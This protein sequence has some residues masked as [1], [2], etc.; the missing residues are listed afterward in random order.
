ME[1]NKLS[2]GR[3]AKI[4][5]KWAKTMT[6]WLIK[7]SSKN[8]KQWQVISFEGSKGGESRGI[9]DLLA[10]RRNH[11]FS[12]EPLKAGDLFEII[13]IQVKGGNAQMP[14]KEDILRL[15]K[16][17]KYYHAKYIVLADWKKGKVPTLYSLINS[18]W[19][20]IEAKDI[21]K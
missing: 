1:N 4:T 16:V 5:G 12:V 3:H 10:I 8:S 2:P 17:G 13:L 6:R 19:N 20:R 9:V 15:S 21:F 18:S 7:Y 14:I 11:K